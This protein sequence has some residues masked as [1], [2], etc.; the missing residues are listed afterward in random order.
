MRGP[1]ATKLAVYGYAVMQK[2]KPDDAA[3][4]V[5]QD[6]EHLSTWQS[7]RPWIE[8]SSCGPSRSIFESERCWPSPR[9]GL[10]GQPDQ[11]VGQLLGPC[12][13]LATR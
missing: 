9:G 7:R 1:N 4:M 3:W 2:L 5:D 8:L 10:P 11:A 13:R 12:Q 6:D